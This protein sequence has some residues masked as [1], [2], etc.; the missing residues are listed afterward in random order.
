MRFDVLTLF[1]EMVEGALS[2]S[3]LGRARTAGLFEL[4]VHDIRVHGLGRHRVVDDTPYG[5]GS[6]MVLRVDVV[7]A[8]IEAVR[9]EGS[10]VVLTE[11]SGARFDQ[12]KAEALG[13]RAHVIIVCGHY[14]GVD[15][16]VRAHLVDEVL[17][18]GDFVL[19]GGEYAAMVMVDAVARLIPGVLGN[20]ESTRE[21]S[22]APG[23]ALE[24]PQY[25]R[26][27]VFRDWEVPDILVSG[28]HGR[29]SEWRAEQGR[30]LTR[31][32]RPDLHVEPPPRPEKRGRRRPNP[33]ADS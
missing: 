15:A 8:A 27:R 31:D 4:G 10:H 22:F 7:A 18:I 3:I 24:Y 17:S 13:Q 30:A 11:P 6:G 16:R 20:A 1:P 32:V 12:R 29:V 5:G 19:T 26:P 28:H 14:E 21:E 2:H 33:G 23:H 9:R 25:T